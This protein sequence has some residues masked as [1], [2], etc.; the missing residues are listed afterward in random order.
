MLPSICSVL[1]LDAFVPPLC[2]EQRLECHVNLMAIIAVDAGTQGVKKVKSSSSAFFLF[3][4][5]I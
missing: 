3:T 5:E 4:F 2:T 1:V